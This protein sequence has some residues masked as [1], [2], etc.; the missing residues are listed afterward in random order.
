MAGHQQ[1]TWSSDRVRQDARLNERHYGAVQGFLKS[2]PELQAAF[3]ERTIRSW[4]R[5][6]DTKPPPITEEH[7]EW[8][9]APA[10]TTESLADC[11]RRALACFYDR[12]APAMFDEADPSKSDRTVVVVAHANTIR[13]L[14]AAFDRV[15]D[16]DVPR[17]HVPN[18]VPILYR[19]DRSTRELISTKLQSA[20]GGS[21]ARWLLSSENHIQIRDAVQP[22]GMLTRALFD[23]WV[24]LSGKSSRESSNRELT[25]RE[26][27]AGVNAFLSDDDEPGASS[28][29][30]IAVAKKI[31]RELSA[32]E[33]SAGARVTLADFEKLAAEEVADIEKSVVRQND[34]RCELSNSSP[35]HSRR[36]ANV[37]MPCGR[38]FVLAERLAR[39]AERRLKGRRE[40]VN[41]RERESSIWVCAQSALLRDLI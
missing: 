21:H 4:R 28:C 27:E 29:A 15:P 38:S 33:L 7:S 11:Q 1:D 16:E 24:E 36:A 6:M 3:G 23:S 22:G 12:I 35:S 25:V 13:S 17:L 32:R 39:R 5:S 26:M 20:A 14:M 8:R 31:I 30:V 40:T 37:L 9:P 2:D 41:E 10:P 18:S 19:F 34:V